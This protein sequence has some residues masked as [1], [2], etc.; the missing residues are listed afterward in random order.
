MIIFLSYIYVNRIATRIIMSLSFPDILY[1][2][3]QNIFKLLNSEH[4]KN[5]YKSILTLNINFLFLR[6][7]TNT[8][9]INEELTEELILLCGKI[10]F[11]IILKILSSS[12]NLLLI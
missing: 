6:V 12:I 1:I 8:K 7:S 10:N 11:K 9:S 4:R 5:L 2:N 3:I